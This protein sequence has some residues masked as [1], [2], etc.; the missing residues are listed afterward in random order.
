[1][2]AFF[3]SLLDS[4]LLV[5][6]IPVEPK[7]EETDEM[8]VDEEE[9]SQQPKEKTQSIYTSDDEVDVFGSDSDDLDLNV[10]LADR[11]TATKPKLPKVR[12][13]PVLRPNPPPPGNSKREVATPKSDG[14][15][16]PLLV[17]C[18]ATVMRQWVREF[19]TWAP[20]FRVL[21]YHTSNAKMKSKAAA[22][23]S[24][25]KTVPSTTTSEEIDRAMARIVAKA[26]SDPYCP[27][28]VITTYEMV[29]LHAN[30][31]VVGT[32]APDWRYVVLDEGHKLR[33]PNAAITTV[34]KQF[35]TVHRIL[36]TGAPIQNNLVELWSLFDFVFPGK[37]GVRID[38]PFCLSDKLSCV[39]T[40]LGDVFRA[41]CASYLARRLC[42][43]HGIGSSYGLQVCRTL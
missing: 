18:P 10:A 21:L 1:V 41:V 30:R 34:C 32:R 9:L 7:P 27:T 20:Q 22:N 17:V 29:R 24:V 40:E 5:E 4:G 25:N 12:P 6:A 36:M 8:K 14:V 37:L 35:S 23:R 11:K 28:V 16:R 39:G 19:H 31:L 15:A 13:P 42:Q 33:N 3:Q 2:I 38:R 26:I 43:C